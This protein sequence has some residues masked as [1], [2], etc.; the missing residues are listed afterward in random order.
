MVG[1][2]HSENEHRQRHEPGKEC[3]AGCFGG[4]AQRAPS[5]G[6]SSAAIDISHQAMPRQAGPQHVWQNDQMQKGDR[7]GHGCEPEQEPMRRDVGRP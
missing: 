6:N 2:L 7:K 4:N 3:I 5:R 1:Q